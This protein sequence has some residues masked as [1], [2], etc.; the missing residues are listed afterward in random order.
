[1]QKKIKDSLFI[2]LIMCILEVQKQKN[3]TSPFGCTRLSF[4]STKITK[5]GITTNK[6]SG[7]GGLPL[8]LRY[9]EQIGL[10]GL[11]SRN[12]SSLLTGNNK[13]LQLQ[14]FVKQIVAFFIDGTNMA[15]S[16]FDQS[17]KDEGYAC[18]LECKTDQLAS[19]H[20]IKRFF[21]KLSC[22]TN[23]VFNKILNELFI[24]RLHIS[25]P[26][27][28]EL[29]I[30]TMV[31]DNDDAAKREG[32][33]VTYKRKKG[34]QPLHICWGSFLIDVTF[35]KGSAH[36]NHG[37]D[38]TDRVRSIVNLIRKRYSKETPIVVCGDSGF[39]D[40]KAYEIFEQEL[41]IHYIT[42]GKLYKDVTEYVKALPNNA[43]GKITKNKAVWQFAEFAS[44]LKSWSKFRRCFFTKL[45]RDDT[46]Q[47]VM[48]FGKP[49]SVIYTNIGNCPVADRRL[50]AAGGDEWFKADTIIRKSH[51]RGADELIHRSI[52]E[53]ATR[54]QLPFK[55]FG[56]NRAYYFM[57]VVTHFI[58]EAYKQDVTAEVIPVTVYPNTF[59]RKLI[60]FAVKITSRA[61]S[62]VLNVTRVIYETINIEELW[63]RCQSPPKIQFA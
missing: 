56:M 13:G 59:R 9:T 25:K 5:I 20:Q 53:L 21:G 24:W 63:E 8:F 12:V 48:G 45:H 42:T 10:Y 41:N 40:Q 15:I 36:S 57:L 52:K 32:C 60:D 34:F 62:I 16:S 38:Y 4:M 28:I 39:A 29:G 26:K 54:E 27:V 30:D 50:R 44:K 46:G 33:E 31:L 47:Y 6:I 35:R 43:F 51:Q 49:D 22:I 55:S 7:R 3:N 19:S 23:P 17:K 2:T 61:R 11:I 1:M 37:S 14:Q 18:L 58:F